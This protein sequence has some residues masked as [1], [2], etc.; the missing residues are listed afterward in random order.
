MVITCIYFIV[1]LKH[2]VISMYEKKSTKA[3]YFYVLRNCLAVGLMLCPLTEGVGVG[4]G[5]LMYILI[6]ESR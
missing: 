4:A 2:I 1:C 3:C 5:G 6:Y